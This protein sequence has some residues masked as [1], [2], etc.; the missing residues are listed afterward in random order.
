MN[1]LDVRFN[2]Y[3]NAYDPYRKTDNQ[4]S[5]YLKKQD[6][7]LTMLQKKVY[8]HLKSRAVTIFT[9]NKETAKSYGSMHLIRLMQ[10]KKTKQKQQQ[11]LSYKLHK[12][13]NIFN[14]INVKISYSSMSNISSVIA[15][16]N[17]SLPQ[18][19]ITKCGCNCRVKN[20]CPLQN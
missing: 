12:L 16:H 10:N 15:G 11:H 13:Q 1:F 9:R 7:L 3:K 19:K 5:K 4:F 18:S 14:K 17:E 20:T 6:H 8:I 2:L